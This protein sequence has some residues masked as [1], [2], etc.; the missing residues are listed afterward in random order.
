MKPI[1]L[2][3]HP[4]GGRYIEVFRSKSEVFTSGEIKRTALTH[5]YFSLEPGEI[6]HFHKV[7]SDEIWNLYEGEELLLYLWDQTAT[8]MEVVK[9]SRSERDY[10][11]VV[12]AGIWQAAKAKRE[13]VLVGCT[14]APGFE[15]DDFELM[16]PK[17]EEAD[18]IINNHPDLKNLI[19]PK[20]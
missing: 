8:N 3:E 1:N 19:T 17:G 15:F 12:P 16:D 13:T 11:H 2:M 20:H 4:E 6:S 14:V 10:C 5:I 9:L 18:F 7:N